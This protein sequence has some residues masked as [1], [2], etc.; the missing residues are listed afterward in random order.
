[1]FMTGCVTQPPFVMT[2]RMFGFL[3]T[4]LCVCRYSGWSFFAVAALGGSR[5]PVSWCL[6]HI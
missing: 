1:M 3:G 2:I 4:E 5:V 6:N